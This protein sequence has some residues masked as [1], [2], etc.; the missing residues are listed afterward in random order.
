MCATSV[1]PWASTPVRPQRAHFGL[2]STSYT[3][4]SISADEIESII[5]VSEAANSS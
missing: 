1:Q 3:P 4:G 2:E 5:E